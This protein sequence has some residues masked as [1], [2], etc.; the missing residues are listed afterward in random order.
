MTA[1]SFTLCG[2]RRAPSATEVRAGVGVIVVDARGRVLLEKRSDCGQWGLPGGRIN[3]G[4]DIETAARR[5]VKEETGLDVRVTGLQGVYSELPER[6]AIC[7][8]ERKPVQFVDVILIANVISGRL[9]SSGESEELA[10]FWRHGLP[11]DIVPPAVSPLRHY[12][13]GERGVIQ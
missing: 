12:V 13:R 9:R 7:P 6:L 8:G 1:P 4:E 11:H 3:P 10:F 2:E 5:E